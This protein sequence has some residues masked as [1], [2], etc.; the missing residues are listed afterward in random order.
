MGKI[1]YQKLITCECRS[2]C[3]YCFPAHLME[4]YANDKHRF[5]FIKLTSITYQIKSFKIILTELD[6]KNKAIS[7]RII[8]S[9]GLTI[10]PNKS[11]VID[12]PIPLSKTCASLF[13]IISHIITPAFE[14]DY[15]ETME[16]KEND[17]QALMMA[18]AQPSLVSDDVSIE[19]T[20]RETT[21]QK[22]V[23]TKRKTPR[24]HH[25][26][27]YL[28]NHFSRIV[29]TS[30]LILLGIVSLAGVLPSSSSSD[31]LS[32][33]EDGKLDSNY[34]VAV[35]NPS[36]S[37]FV[38]KDGLTFGLINIDGYLSYYVTNYDKE[39]FTDTISIP[40]YVNNY[41]VDGIA[42][43]TFKNSSINYVNFFTNNF[44][45]GDEAFLGSS[46]I[47]LSMNNNYS[48]SLKYVGRRAFADCDN[49]KEFTS[50]NIDFLGDRA[51]EACN[52]LTS[53]TQTKKTDGI[54]NY[55]GSPF[56]NCPKLAEYDSSL[57][58][59]QPNN[60][61]TPLFQDCKKL[62]KIFLSS[63]SIYFDSTGFSNWLLKG[64][65]YFNLS[66]TIN[67]VSSVEKSMFYHSNLKHLTINGDFTTL[68][69]Y[70]I[71][72]NP[73]FVSLTIS[74]SNSIVVKSSVVKNCDN[75]SSFESSG[76]SV[77]EKKAFN[78]C[79]SLRRVYFSS[80]PYIATD[81]FPSW[82]QVYYET[83][84]KYHSYGYYYGSD[85][86]VEVGLIKIDSIIK[87]PSCLEQGIVYGSTF[88]MNGT[89]IKTAIPSTV[90]IFNKGETCQVCNQKI[91][92][93]NEP[94]F[95]LT[96]HNQYLINNQIESNKYEL[97]DVG[98]TKDSLAICSTN[99]EK[100]S[101]G[102]FVTFNDESKGGSFTITGSQSYNITCTYSA[103]FVLTVNPGA[104]LTIS[105]RDQKADLT[106]SELS[107]H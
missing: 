74:S 54:M 105:V 79:T 75:F 101:V 15:E 63:P 26:S 64:D 51:F 76:V 97:C 20:P 30:S 91:S 14:W 29:L 16:K 89:Y 84:D 72:D 6:D 103:F 3:P 90:H 55:E 35:N 12:T 27:F 5:V 77:I 88:A 86:N 34:H 32:Y 92:D 47:S 41:I 39:K 56:Y 33:P 80:Y 31:N 25:H 11:L 9:H 13:V 59:A 57:I 21:P 62:D 60:S 49:L 61:I 93:I 2:S 18:Q 7:S 106:I 22:N 58:S 100:I 1:S 28:P 46:L 50:K 70:L 37:S 53:F 8:T 85:R 43:G 82:T 40:Y 23:I 38:M 68:P 87:Y 95:G 17:E 52:R 67:K 48:F 44:T 45:I 107:I 66:L 36:F 24:K 4:V 10:R 71:T 102:F 73:S 42:P 69:S 104:N 65:T 78:G 19:E 96:Y 94:P 81:A 83:S 98:N 99:Y